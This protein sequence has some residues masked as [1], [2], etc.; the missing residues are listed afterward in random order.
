MIPKGPSPLNPTIGS[1]TGY[2]VRVA[3]IIPTNRIAQS[4]GVANLQSAVIQYQSWYRD[5]MQ[6][7]GFG[8]K[9]FRYETQADGV[10]PKIYTVTVAATDDYLRGDI[11]GRTIAAASAAGVPVWTSKQVWWLIPEAHLETSNGSISGGTSLGASFGSGDD[12]GVSMVGGDALARYKPA[13]FTNDAP[14]AG[15]TI[16]EIGPYPLVQSVSFPWFEGATFSS[17]SSSVLGA[18]IH[19]TS[20]GFGLPH[21]FRNDQNF[22][23]N[24]MGNGL[25]GIRGA[26]FPDRYPSDYTRAAYG[27]TLALSVSR[28][29]NSKGTYTDN[30]K[31]ILAVS[32]TGTNSPV[33]GL[34]QISFTASDASGLYAAW[35]QLNGD[36][37]GEMMLSGTSTSQTFATPY[38]TPGKTNQYTISVFDTQ[39]N[40]QTADT[41]IVPRTGFN[42]AP[43]PFITVSTPTA[44]VG[45]VV[46]LDASASTDPDG[47]SANM[48]VEWDLNGDGIFDTAPTTTKTL[49]CQ[50]A[51]VGDRF[52]RARLTD[53]LGAQSVSAPIALRLVAPALGI[54]RLS[55]RVQLSWS[56]NALGFVLEGSTTLAPANW[57][58]VTQ[59]VAVIGGQNTI[60][61]TNPLSGKF[62]HLKR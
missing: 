32:T 42:Q 52:I 4:N 7:N 17:I 58:A 12:P 22:N 30:T 37:V 5:Q 49:S 53:S 47:N 16:P 11:W 44:L 45:Q 9:T 10:T 31:P 6:R 36:L 1:V 24:L 62:F 57:E 26:L 40:K 60:T 14:Y 29:F 21:D 19:E 43:Q 51:T 50:F 34:L 35:L 48:Q 54:T 3:Y 55:N 46:V 33:N 38:Y 56:T 2:L 41:Y 8:P 39:A 15:Q 28:Y 18:G 23:G 25:R 59:T 27:S 20:H 61:L 13:F